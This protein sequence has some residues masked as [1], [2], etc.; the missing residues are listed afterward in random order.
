MLHPISD[1]S[2]CSNLRPIPAKFVARRS[3]VDFDS[4][5]QGILYKNGGGNIGSILAVLVSSCEDDGAN[6]KV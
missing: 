2:S 6:I 1:K 5:K 3:I 4:L